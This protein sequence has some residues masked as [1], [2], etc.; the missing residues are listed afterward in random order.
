MY[1][2]VITLLPITDTPELHISGYVR[3][4]GPLK[5]TVQFMKYNDQCSHV[6][7]NVDKALQIYK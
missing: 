5:V 7:S 1:S 4:S 3:I 2:G 6:V